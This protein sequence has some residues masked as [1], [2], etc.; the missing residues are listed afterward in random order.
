MERKLT[1]RVLAS[2]LLLAIIVTSCGGESAI[3]EEPTQGQEIPLEDTTSAA[4][5]SIVRPPD[6]VK[7]SNDFNARFNI[8]DTFK[9]SSIEPLIEEYLNADIAERESLRKSVNDSLSDRLLAYGFL[10]STESIVSQSEQTLF[11]GLL[12]LSLEDASRDFKDNI[13]GLAL[14]YTSAAVLEVNPELIFGQVA[15]ISSDKFSR[16]ME[17]FLNRE[18]AMKTA[19]IFG[20]SYYV[21]PQTGGF[22]YFFKSFIID[23]AAFVQ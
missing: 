18:E 16:I 6:P 8:P 19:D 11:Y 9:Y 7:P 2:L 3:V 1:F 4:S 17:D 22:D 13:T 14:I 12:A 15:A 10:S 20:Y 5:D 21:D 23:S